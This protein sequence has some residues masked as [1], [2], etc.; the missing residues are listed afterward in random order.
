MITLETEQEY[1]LPRGTDTHIAKGKF[2]LS[3]TRSMRKYYDRGISILYGFARFR[4]Y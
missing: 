4:R 3:H 1:G 2:L